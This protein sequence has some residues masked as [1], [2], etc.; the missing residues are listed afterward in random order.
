MS[1]PWRSEI[2]I[3]VSPDRVAALKVCGLVHRH[4]QAEALWKPAYSDGAPAWRAAVD[5]LKQNISRLGTASRAG[6]IISNRLTHYAL[7]NP[8]ENLSQREHGRYVEHKLQAIFGD[9]SA[10]W[11]VRIA[12]PSKNGALLVAGIDTALLDAIKEALGPALARTAHIEPHFS[13]A[14]NR[15]REHLTAPS[16]WFVMQEEKHALIGRLSGGAWQSLRGRHLSANSPD[17]LIPAIDREHALH[18]LAE[19]V[20]KVY[21]LPPR[22][23]VPLPVIEPY[24]VQLLQDPLPDGFPLT[25]D[26][27]DEMAA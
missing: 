12:G 22:H 23:D 5:T 17:A 8:P 2:R 24:D 4:V 1:R 19:P 3:A 25:S 9:L 15:L 18:N 10:Q 11:T 27:G 13:A 16:G 20:R 26:H 6:V 7:L 21:L 14:F